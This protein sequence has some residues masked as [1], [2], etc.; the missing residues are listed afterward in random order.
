[1]TGKKIRYEI[2]P[3][4]EILEEWLEHLPVDFQSNGVTVFKDR[5]EVK[6]FQPS[7]FE[8]NV[9][10]FKIPHLINRF[11]YVYLRGSK[12]ARSFQNAL[13][14]LKA[15]SSTPEPVAWIECQSYGKLDRSFY[16]SL[17]F[18]HDF[19]LRDVL[20]NLVPD[21]RNILTQWVYFTW[22][23]LHQKGIFHLDYSPGN[24]L[25]R[26][27]GEKY[28]FSIVDL[29]RMKFIPVDFLMGIKNFRQLDTDEESLRQIASEYAILCEASPEQAV[30]LLLKYDQKNKAFRNRKNKFNDFLGKS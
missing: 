30:E 7:G 15:G 8:L 16:V 18:Q 22:L 6:V 3:G 17:N 12:A 21:K 5:N 26:K 19:S 10:A 25:I 11:A 27:E 24:T 23:H 14:L 28:Q 2:A 9:K 1:M 4:Y 29:N 13:K 20:N